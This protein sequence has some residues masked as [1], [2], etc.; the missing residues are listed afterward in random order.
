MSDCDKQVPFEYI[1]SYVTTLSDRDFERFIAA[2]EDEHAQPNQ[3]LAIAAE[4]YNRRIKGDT[5]R[6]P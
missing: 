6:V 2:I 3:S 4:R 1:E 5:T